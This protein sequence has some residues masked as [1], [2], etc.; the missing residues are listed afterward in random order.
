MF[1]REF[2]P[3]SLRT[4]LCERAAKLTRSPVN[5]CCNP[6]YVIANGFGSYFLI[7]LKEKELIPPILNCI[8]CSWGCVICPSKDTTSG[9]SGIWSP[10]VKRAAAVVATVRLS[11]W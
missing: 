4:V 7:G 6:F 5:V 1:F 11:V 8:L 2:S 3:L 10:R 9:I